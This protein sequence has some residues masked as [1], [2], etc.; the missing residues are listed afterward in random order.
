M[1]HKALLVPTAFTRYKPTL[2]P[3]AA[4]MRSLVALAFCFFVA[5]QLSVQPLCAQTADPVVAKVNG[6]QIHESDVT[7]AEEQLGPAVA[8]MDPST[9]HQ[10]IVSFLIDLKLAA[11]A[12][13]SKKLRDNDEFKKQAAFAL[14]RLSMDMLLARQGDGVVTDA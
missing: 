7:L 4:N 11:K 3:V 6:A 9:K 13:D 8:Q 10:N 5:D 1:R 2:F 12:A 14:D